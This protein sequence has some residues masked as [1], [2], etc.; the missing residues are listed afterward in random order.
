MFIL[1]QDTC[2]VQPNKVVW[3]RLPMVNWGCFFFISIYFF[4]IVFCVC[5]WQIATNHGPYI[6]MTKEEICQFHVG[7]FRS[8]LHLSENKCTK[9]TVSCVL[10]LIV[11]CPVCPRCAPW[12][13]APPFNHLSYPH[14][15]LHANKMFKGIIYGATQ[16]TMTQPFP[17]AIMRMYCF[18]TYFINA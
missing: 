16:L 13:D 4:L 3:N 6:N 2:L 17:I 7:S 15:P 14:T 12:T 5:L 18:V 8:H 9:S 11:N 1:K 10:S